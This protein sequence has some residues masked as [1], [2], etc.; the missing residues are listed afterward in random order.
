MRLNHNALMYYELA[1]DLD[2]FL[3][4]VVAFPYLHVVCSSKN[5]TIEMEKVL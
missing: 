3:A 1:Y 2:G 4:K 5:I